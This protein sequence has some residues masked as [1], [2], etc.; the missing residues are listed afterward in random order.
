M[1]DYLVWGFELRVLP[2]GYSWWD[3]RLARLPPGT[4]STFVEEV[5]QTSRRAASCPGDP[6]ALKELEG[7]A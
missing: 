3:G 1:V 6:S 2:L 5:S 7:D 4:H